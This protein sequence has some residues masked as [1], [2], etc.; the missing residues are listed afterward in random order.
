MTLAEA[1]APP[2]LT[3]SPGQL[4]P[5]CFGC[6]GQHAWRIR[7]VALWAPLHSCIVLSYMG[8]G[9]LQGPHRFPRV[10]LDSQRALKGSWRVPIDSPGFYRIR[11]G[12]SRLHGCR[13]PP[14]TLMRIAE[15]VEEQPA[16]FVEEQGHVQC[17]F[18][19]V[20]GS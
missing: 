4:C 2:P 13:S 11:R 15:L 7:P 12:P 19:L 5:L 6:G 9:V 3:L 17:G 8:S 16:V 18:I 20:C 10:L 1:A 14:F